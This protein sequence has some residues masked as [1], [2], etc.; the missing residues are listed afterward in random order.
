MRGWNGV[1]RWFCW[2][3]YGLLEL[4]LIFYVYYV[5][6]IEFVVVGECVFWIGE[7]DWF[8]VIE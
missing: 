6:D 4:L 1:G 2:V 7:Y 8:L 3:L 5:F